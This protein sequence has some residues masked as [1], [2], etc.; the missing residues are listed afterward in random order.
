MLET[1]AVWESSFIPKILSALCLFS[2]ICSEDNNVAAF[3]CSTL[4]NLEMKYGMKIILQMNS[5][6]RS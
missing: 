3:G 5:F 4:E 6:Y 1:I 2:F